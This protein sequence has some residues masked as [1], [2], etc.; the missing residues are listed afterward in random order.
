MSNDLTSPLTPSQASLSE[1]DYDALCAT[2]SATA[3]GRR[4]LAEY[5]RRNHPT[6]T[7]SALAAI[8]RMEQTISGERA[9]QSF[10]R[11]RFDVV[12]MAEA[13]AR[14]KAE[15][16]AIKPDVERYGQIEAATEELDSI[17]HMTE[18][19]TSRIL[20]A[21]EQI[22]E[23]SWALRE[24]G[25]DNNFCDQ[26]DAQTTET[27]TACSFQDLTG[28]R[29]RK[30]IQVLSYLE[31][32]INAMI[33][34]W[35]DQIPQPTTAKAEKAPEDPLING[36]PPPGGGLEQADVDIMMEP[37]DPQVEDR[38]DA[39]IEDIGRS[40]LALEPIGVAVSDASVPTL[41][42]A[43]EAD[44]ADFLLGPAANGNSSETQAPHARE[45]PSIAHL[46]RLLPATQPDSAAVP[47]VAVGKVE[48][49]PAPQSTAPTRDDPLAPLRALSDEEKIALFS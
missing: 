43:E 34:I 14:T 25:V 16:A 15:I 2:L 21:A 9:A 39:S 35:G 22:Q 12:E 48:I 5:L 28:Q 47:E 44:P 20:A 19:A 36:P 33:A 1:A 38:R 32:R 6:D 7:Q 42:P 40:M 26:L 17:V 49:V 3:R 30:V 41:K 45:A 24:Q 8:Q 29:T 10:D 31:D 4:F 13:I 37:P 23:I 46:V 11:F 27:F 18:T